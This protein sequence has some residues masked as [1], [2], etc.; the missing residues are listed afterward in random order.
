M[1][2]EREKPKASE[3]EKGPRSAAKSRAKSSH[4][5]K[6]AGAGRKPKE[7][8]VAREAFTQAIERQIAALVPRLVANL[9]VLANGGYERVEE[10]YAPGEETAPEGGDAKGKAKAK[11]PGPGM[12]LVERKVSVAEPDREANRYL[13]DRLL[14]KPAIA[15]TPAP[16]LADDDYEIDLSDAGGGGGSDA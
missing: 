15:P 1:A 3:T 7:V 5:G 6:R 13:L 4:G 11:K 14:G 9:M 10:K 2:K 16:A 8:T 12:V